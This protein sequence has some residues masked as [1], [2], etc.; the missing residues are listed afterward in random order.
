MHFV[1]NLFD[2]DLDGEINPK[3]ISDIMKNVLTCPSK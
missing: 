1:F 2:S 3:D